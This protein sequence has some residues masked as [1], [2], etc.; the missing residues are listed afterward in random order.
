MSCRRDRL[1]RDECGVN[2]TG[3]FPLVLIKTWARKELFVGTASFRR[4]Q[5]PPVK[6]TYP[7]QPDRAQTPKICDEMSAETIENSEHFLV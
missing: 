4:A 5:S 1:L 3:T 7:F 2:P 6:A